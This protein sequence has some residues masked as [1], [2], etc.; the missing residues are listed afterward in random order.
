V[1]ELSAAP[2]TTILW[3]N[4]K[5]VQPASETVVSAHDGTDDDAID[6]GNEQQFIAEAK[7]AVDDAFGCVS[8]R[9]VWKH[10]RPEGNETIAIVGGEGANS[11]AWSIGHRECSEESNGAVIKRE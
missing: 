4:G 8:G 1:H 2:T 11:K 10:Q 3:G 9:I 7:L 5:V 6:N